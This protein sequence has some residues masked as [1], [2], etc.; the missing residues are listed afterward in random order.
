MRRFVPILVVMLLAVGCASWVPVGG[1]YQGSKQN[2]KA[3]LP[4]G[5]L[6]VGLQPGVTTKDPLFKGVTITRDGQLLQRIVLGQMDVGTPLLG[7]KKSFEVGMLSQEA[8]EVILDNFRMNEKLLEF[9]VLS[10][11]PVEVGGYPGF[12][13]EFDVKY[14]TLMWKRMVFYG[15]IAEDRFCFLHYLAPR[16]HYFDR[17][18]QTFEAVVRSYRPLIRAPSN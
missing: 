18:L 9:E 11:T 3:E 15:T 8:A 17:D 7:T 6:K 4:E 13:L 1:E 12:R 5:W 14:P 2:F 16:R 10:N